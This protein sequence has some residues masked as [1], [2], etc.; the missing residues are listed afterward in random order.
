MT[1]ARKDSDRMKQSGIMNEI[2]KEIAIN[3]AEAG[4]IPW[5]CSLLP[6]ET[7]LADQVVIHK[8]LS[9]PARLKILFLLSSQ[10]LCVCVIKHCL[11]MADS[12]LSYHLSVLRE[13][14]LVESHH[15]KNWLIYNLTAGGKRTVVREN[16]VNTDQPNDH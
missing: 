9:D 8:A 1:A 12:K 14:G 15:D 16:T 2:P 3:L 11:R 6:S 13:A 10:P 7:D 4:G 5:L